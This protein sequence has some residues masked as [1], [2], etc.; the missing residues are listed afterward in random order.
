MEGIVQSAACDHAESVEAKWS[1]ERGFFEVHAAAIRMNP[2]FPFAAA[3]SGPAN[4]AVV[5]EQATVN[6]WITEIAKF[7]GDG[8]FHSK[9]IGEEAHDRGIRAIH[10]CLGVF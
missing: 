9:V 7:G 4:A 3:V 10:I 5:E 6:I 1:A 2:G 8:T